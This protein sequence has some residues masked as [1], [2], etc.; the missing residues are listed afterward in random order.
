MNVDKIS[1]GY[2]IRQYTEQGEKQVFAK[3]K[4]EVSRHVGK[5]L[6]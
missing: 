1:N 4:N 6:G 5:L 2:V 3:N